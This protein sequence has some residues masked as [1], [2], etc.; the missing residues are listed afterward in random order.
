M[1]NLTWSNH[2]F[3]N[4]RNSSLVQYKEGLYI[5]SRYFVKYIFSLT[6]QVKIAKK[7]KKVFSFRSLPSDFAEKMSI[8][9]QRRRNKFVLKNLILAKFVFV[10]A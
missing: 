5:F 4:Y 7:K 1:S 8:V 3:W 10:K 6:F 2:S 9:A